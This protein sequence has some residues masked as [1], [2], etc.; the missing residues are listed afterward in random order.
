MRLRALGLTPPGYE[1]SHLRCLKN[2]PA[3]TVPRRAQHE[4]AGASKGTKVVF[5]DSRWLGQNATWPLALDMSKALLWR[6]CAPPEPPERAT[7]V[8]TT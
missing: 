4:G 5:G 2:C 1:L 3:R 6:R 8:R 7:G